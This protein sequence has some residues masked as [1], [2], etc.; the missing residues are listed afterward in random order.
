MMAL[1][2]K[3]MY[4]VLTCS[5]LSGSSVSSLPSSSTCIQLFAEPTRPKQSGSCLIPAPMM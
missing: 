4:F 2:L 5:M 3:L 1:V